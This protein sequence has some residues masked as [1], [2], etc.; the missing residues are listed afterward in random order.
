MSLVLR[1]LRIFSYL[2]LAA[3]AA[4]FVGLAVVSKVTG[5]PL[6]M[7]SFPWKAPELVTWLFALGFLGGLTVIAAVFGGKLRVALPLWGII[8]A[9]LIVRSTFSAARMY[10]GESDFHN[11]LLICAGSV[12][13]ALFSLLQL[14]KTS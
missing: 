8:Q 12:L 3:V 9:F 5:T 10:A 1:L 7:D 13:A 11:A 2:Y 4:A 6:I 14:R